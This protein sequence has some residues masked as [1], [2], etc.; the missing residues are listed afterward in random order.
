M[1]AYDWATLATLPGVLHELADR[2]SDKRITAERRRETLRQLRLTADNMA[3]V[4]KRM[5]DQHP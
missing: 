5:V 4:L 1:N 2:L 3:K